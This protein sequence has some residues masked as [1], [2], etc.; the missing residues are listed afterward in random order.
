MNLHN[1]AATSTER[2]VIYSLVLVL[3]VVAEI[4]YV[5]FHQSFGLCASQNAFGE[6]S[7]E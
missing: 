1:H 3:G 5:D 7:A 4:V 6:K 2:V